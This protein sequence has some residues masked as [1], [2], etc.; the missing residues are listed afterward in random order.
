MRKM[1]FATVVMSLAMPSMV[2]AADPMEL[3][4]LDKGMEIILS[5]NLN[6]YENAQN[7]ETGQIKET[8]PAG[9]S[10]VMDTF[11]FYR[12]SINYGDGKSG[13]VKADDLYGDFADPSAR[14]L[15][16]D[17]DVNNIQIA[18]N[19]VLP[20]P[21]TWVE[22]TESNDSTMRFDGDGESLFIIKSDKVGLPS[23]DELMLDMTADIYINDDAY[24]HNFRYEFDIDG[25]YARYDSFLVKA[26]FASLSCT[27]IDTGNSVVYLLALN[28]LMHGD[29]IMQYETALFNIKFTE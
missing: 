8:L 29:G 20:L 22:S 3:Y 27:T 7:I 10:V 6:V 19:A 5:E 17:L 11:S 4:P 9:S 13:Y 21:V 25:H 2:M 23:L 28:D 26:N 14:Q 16:S 1:L 24:R 12:Y 18:D 15:F